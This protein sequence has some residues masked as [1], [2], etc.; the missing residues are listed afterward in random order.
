VPTRLRLDDVRRAWDSRDPDLVGLAADLADQDDEEPGTPPPREGA[1]TLISVLSEIQGPAFRKKPLDEQAHVRAERFQALVSPNADVPPP[2]RLGLHEVVSALW[3]DNGP[4]ARW[5]L[6][7]VIARVPLR[8]GPWR[9]LKRIFKEAEARDD[10]EVFGALAARVDTPHGSRPVEVTDRTIAYLRRRAWRHLR[11]TARER[12]A[13]YADA[14]ADVLANYEDSTRWA[15]T[16][17]ANHIFFHETG[18]YN[19]TRFRFLKPPSALNDR[20][21]AALW[22]RTPRPLFGLLERAKSD[23]VR[24]FAADAL[25]ADFRASLREVEPGWVARLAGAGS[26][27]VDEFVVWVLNNVPR[28]E[29]AAFRTIGLHEAVL[30]LFDSPSD[31]ARAYAADYARTHAR[32]LPVVQLVLLAD[33]AN[34]AVRKLADDLLQSLDPR[35][36]VGL[37][38]WGRLLES[39]HGH[40][41]AAAVLRKHFGARELTPEWF[42]SRFF[43]ANPAAFRFIQTALAQTHPAASL[44][45]GYFLALVEAAD[46][47]DRPSARQVAEFAAEQ[48]ARFDLNALDRDALLRL[49]LRDATRGRAC[50]WV[51]EGRLRAQTLGLDFLKALAFHP[52]WE[53]DPW[54]SALRRDGPDWARALTFD[55][56][57]SDLALGWL[58]DVRRFTPSELGF[59]WLLRLASRAEPRYHD[60]AVETMTKGFSPADFAPQPADTPAT[61]TATASATA[62]D[63]KGASFLF[64][65]KLATM[66]RKEAE[67]KVRGAGGAV[68]SGVTPKLHYLVIGDEGSPL[69]GAGKKGSKQLKGEELNAAGANIKIVSETAF[70]KM[71]T[72][73]APRAEAGGALAGA[74]RLWEMAC[75]PGPADAPL[76]RFAV[77]YLRRHHPDI[78]PAETDRP[79]DP[80][81]EIP[82]EFLSFDRVKPLFAETRKPL[83]DL[84]LDL[85]RWEFTRWAPPAVELV[86]LAESPHADVRRF[87]AEALLADDAP[88]HRRYRIDPESL[89]PAAVF[90]FCESADESTRALGL[91]LIDRSP[92]FRL[93]EELFR[94]T[95]SPDRRVRAFVV[96]ALWSLYRDRGITD[97]WTPYI[98]PAPT[99]GAAARKAAAAQAETRGTGAPARPDR[100]PAAPRGIWSFLRRALFEIPPPRPEKGEGSAPGAGD[101]VKPLPARKAK[102][103]LVETV[104]DLAAEDAD[105]ARG[106]LPLLEEFMASRGPGERAACLVAVTRIR[107]TH[108]GLRPDRD[109]TAGG[110]AP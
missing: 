57:L 81:A 19:R 73:R 77:R 75:A 88:E 28:F 103:A 83:R 2:E 42:L 25:R 27:A 56:G 45:A 1:L 54:L 15:D 12:P 69:Y 44:G 97:G 90:R 4:F 36:D 85:A 7:E 64:T 87:V 68:A 61:E 53:S 58:R 49:F 46:A 107:H 34:A 100:L 95:E 101:R 17:V 35:D 91:R 18:D 51:N 98:P 92:R 62:V 108:P 32:D 43:T 79:V 31:P 6:L 109:R 10:T 29:Q 93:P 96:R 106:V 26:R 5:C 50:S 82:A 3:E 70:L 80:G 76:A 16:W 59:A 22:R 48:L 65:G 72:G 9:A 41:L 33:N 23:R 47:P 11:R 86:S 39:R 60:F 71:L 89:G 102:L 21:Y 67:D 30:R 84:A 52:D 110:V 94:L 14:A 63:L 20:A 105:F 13:C 8:Y 24:Q 74:E 37:E 55:E 40:D 38:A 78:A 104:R 66:Q 99:V